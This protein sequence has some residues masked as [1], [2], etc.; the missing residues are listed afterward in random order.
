MRGGLGAL[1]GVVCISVAALARARGVCRR[2][3]RFLKVCELLGAFF[4]G[5]DTKRFLFVIVKVACVAGSLAL[6]NEVSLNLKQS[7]KFLSSRR[8]QMPKHTT[9][10]IAGLEVYSTFCKSCATI[11]DGHDTFSDRQKLHVF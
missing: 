2:R 1:Q 6:G 11:S 3:R 5:R 8:F 9:V 7:K 10:T 4:R